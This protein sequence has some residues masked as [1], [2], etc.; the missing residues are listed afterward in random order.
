LYSPIMNKW[1]S[2]IADYR[3]WRVIDVGSSI[4]TTDFIDKKYRAEAVK[5][6]AID[7]VTS[8]KPPLRGR[9][10]QAQE[11]KANWG[12]EGSKWFRVYRP[13]LQ[14]GWFWLGQSLNQRWAL[15]VRE[16][17]GDGNA[18]APVV[19]VDSFHTNHGTKAKYDESWWRQY[20]TDTDKYVC[21]GDYYE[22]GVTTNGSFTPPK[23]E[24][25]PY[26]NNIRAVRKD[27]CIKATIQEIENYSNA[28]TTDSGWI[29]VYQTEASKDSP[30]PP[31][32]PYLFK[33]YESKPDNRAT[34]LWK[35]VWMLKA[36]SIYVEPWQ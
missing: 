30:E 2:S 25:D 18:L 5:L 7:L 9:W 26:N 19:C 27:L 4:A 3:T 6:S 35:E 17:G 11:Y 31:V 22:S 16:Q 14:Q 1:I 33:A 20:P 23:F 8:A 36:S 34:N 28:E 24:G 13:K 12:G 15:L 29:S 32:Q 10:V 21:L